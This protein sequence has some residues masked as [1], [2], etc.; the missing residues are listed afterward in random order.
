MLLTMHPP[1]FINPG[2]WMKAIHSFMQAA[3]VAGLQ[4]NF[5]E[6]VKHCAALKPAV[7]KVFPFEAAA[8][9]HRRMLRSAHFGKIVL[10]WT[11]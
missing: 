8:D 5:M 1:R 11:L 2:S 3:L 9:A 6:E 4:D 7:D 10:T